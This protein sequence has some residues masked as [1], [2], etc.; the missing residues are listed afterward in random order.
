MQRTADALDAPSVVL[1]A[2]IAFDYIMSFPG[3]FGDHIL[4]E[5]ST[6]LSVSFLVESLQR[7]RGGVA[8]NIAYNL[9][10]LGV[11]SALYGGVG[12]DFDAYRDAFERLGIDLSNVIEV[13]NELTAS[14]FMMA[15]LR[16]NQIAA[17]YPG[18]SSHSGGISIAGGAAKAEFG[19][20]G[21]TS[22]DAMRRHGEEIAGAGCKLIY[23]PSQQIVAISA[24][25][26]N[27]GI[28]NAWALIS[29]DYE[30]AMM[31]RKIGRGADE[32]TNEVDLLV[33]T[34]GEDGSELRR[35]GKSVRVHAATVEKV[36][37][38]TGAG[39]AYRAGLMKGLLLSDDLEIAGKIGSIAAAYAIEHHGTQQ[40]SYTPQ[41]FVGRFEVAYP[42]SA[43]AVTADQFRLAAP[44][45]R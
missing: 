36:A 38:P 41:E 13:P 5:K 7:L 39:D 16:D 34:Y 32:L 42:E 19:L 21:A 3:S 20:V 4:P 18:A 35:G 43:G 45:M 6:V 24:D 31:E 30:Y 37:D 33:I 26:L 25:D 10:L 17:Y 23:D 28:S 40:H 15:D 29:N 44:A 11:K 2:S 22:P 8:G 9:A 14:A 1:S 27:A 12:M